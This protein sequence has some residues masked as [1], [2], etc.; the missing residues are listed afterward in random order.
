MKKNIFYHGTVKNII[1]AFATVFSDIRFIN[2][3]L[4][5]ITVPLHYSPKEKFVAAIYE[6]LDPN[7]IAT[8]TNLPR[9]GFDMVDMAFASERFSN[10]LSKL[11]STTVSDR[12]YIYTRVPY[13][14]QFNVYLATKKFEESLKIVEQIIPFFTPELN[15]SIHDKP[16]FNLV[17]DVPITLNAASFSIEWE[18]DYEEKRHIEWTM[19]F[20]VKAWLYGDV[21]H[22]EV[23]KKTI[24]EMTELD[25]NKKFA[26][27]T[28]EV[29][30]KTANLTDPYTVV[31]SISEV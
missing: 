1:V 10:P 11:K 16:D 6:N 30:P 28:S 9:M 17:T 19:N 25:V 8:E 2:D 7:N 22:Q 20:T 31:N 21:K 15:I 27:L 4:E 24:I 14:F 13:D 5:E 23:I 3:H 12:K 29:S 26:T 18:G